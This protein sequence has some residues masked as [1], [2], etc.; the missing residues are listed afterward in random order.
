MAV[1]EMLIIANVFYDALELVRKGDD[2][3]EFSPD[4][5]FSGQV[6]N[7]LICKFLFFFF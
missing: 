1:R 2:S 4:Y 3:F 5:S 7:A 6:S